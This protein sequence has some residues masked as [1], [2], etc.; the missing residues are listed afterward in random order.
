M[1]GEQY[2]SNYLITIKESPIQ[3]YTN[4]DFDVLEVA[5][6]HLLC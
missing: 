6:W 1:H 4:G 2:H 3:V 5:S